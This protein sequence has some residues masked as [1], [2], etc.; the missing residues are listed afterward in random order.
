MLRTDIS[1]V[2]SNYVCF[3]SNIYRRECEPNPIK[4]M[5]GKILVFLFKKIQSKK[6]TTMSLSC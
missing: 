2:S 1:K 3:F 5:K 6:K 4:Y